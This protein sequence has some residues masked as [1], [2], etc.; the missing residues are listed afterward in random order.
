[1]RVWRAP[2]TS[3]AG[4]RH[5]VQPLCAA[6]LIEQFGPELRQIGLEPFEF[7]HSLLAD[8][9]RDCF[10]NAAVIGSVLGTR[11]EHASRHRLLLGLPLTYGTMGSEVDE[12]GGKHH[13]RSFSSLR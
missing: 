6:F 10:L 7:L 13:L 3:R 2:A 11:I 8:G 5:H 12:T 1:M 4:G 9:L